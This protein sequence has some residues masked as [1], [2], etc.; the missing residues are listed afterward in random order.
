[1]S[2]FTHRDIRLIEP[3]FNDPLTGLIIE[4]DHLRNKQISGTTHPTVFF[5][6]KNVFQMLESIGSARIEGNNTTISE[7][8]ET[9]LESR[10][11][12]DE[13][14]QEILNIENCLHH[15]EKES[16]NIKINRITISNL[17]KITV[18]N[19]TPPPIGE[20]DHNPGDYRN[21]PVNIKGAKHIPPENY[22]Q[23]EGYMQEL[24]DF[25]NQP[26]PP[27]YDLLKMC[28]AHHRLM[29][30]HP[31]GNG[32]GRLGRVFTYALLVKFGFNVHVGGILNPTAIFCNNREEYYRQLSVADQ[33]SEEN[34]MSWCTY[35]LSGLK[36]EI[37]KIDRL[38]N[39]DYL[40]THILL[41]ALAYSKSMK[42][43]DA[44]EYKILRVTIENQIVQ[45]ATIKTVMKS[46]H[47]TSVSRYIRS[48]KEKKMLVSE[49]ENSRKYHINFI[50]NLLLRGVIKQLEEKGFTP[51]QY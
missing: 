42:Y 45:N 41:P 11:P 22:Q 21:H 40:K 17:H 27:R 48:L 30:I 23:I 9:Q 7:F 24:I 3:T 6:L 13:Q 46:K 14:I 31:F 18:K 5:Q 51:T 26:N 50:Q 36:T 47:I 8:I 15:I 32:N 29:W 28:I 20:G 10:K 4:L 49:G 35:V 44:I 33:G 2:P 25:L 12:V 43:I 1:M 37:E 38:S 16:K 34:L 19:L 39:Y